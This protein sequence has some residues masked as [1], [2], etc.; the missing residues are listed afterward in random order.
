MGDRPRDSQKAK[1][2][3]VETALRASIKPS[4]YDIPAWTDN[5]IHT[6]WYRKRGRIGFVS[7]RRTAT[8]G[9]CVAYNGTLLLGR[10]RYDQLGVL[11]ALAH[12]LADA[13]IRRLNGDKEALHGRTFARALLE[14]VKH[15]WGDT[16]AKE[17]RELYQQ[18]RVK[19]LVVSEAT[20]EKRREAWHDREAEKAKKLWAEWLQDKEKS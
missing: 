8:A 3:N 5:L 7:V 15:Q 2:F 19:R 11:H 13:E 6:A 16:R 14:L 1:V 10:S 18:H 17:L 4:D 12:D 9:R 20:R